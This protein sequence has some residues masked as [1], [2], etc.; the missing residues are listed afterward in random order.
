MKSFL[1]ALALCT[2]A[3]EVIIEGPSIAEENTQIKFDATTS[4]GLAEDYFVDWRVEP[5][6]EDLYY[7]DTNGLILLLTPKPGNYVLFCAISNT[8]GL[9]TRSWYFTVTDK[10]SPDPGPDPGPEPE[11]DSLIKK[12]VVNA[13]R[14][15]VTPDRF[16]ILEPVAEVYK[17]IA[18]SNYDTVMDMIMD[19]RNKTQNALGDDRDVWVPIVTNHIGP[20]LN[21]LM[22]EGKLETIE[23]NKKVWMDI[24]NGIMEVI[25]E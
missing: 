8:E 25:N 18:E 6:V 1:I 22:D 20:A 2:E 23:Q 13:I 21:D 10:N 16:Y 9:D 14:E 17:E 7:V 5:F 24:H 4:K 3:P 15:E 19:T 11:P 12:L